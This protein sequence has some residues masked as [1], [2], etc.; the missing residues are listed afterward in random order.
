[1]EQVPVS[2]VIPHP[3]NARRGSIK[4]I[5]ESL[6][7]HGQY[8]PIIVSS[9]NNYILVGNN[10]WKAIKELGWDTISV[11]YIDVGSD[12]KEKQILLVDNRTSDKAGYDREALEKL[13]S[14]LRESL[15]GTGFSPTEAKSLLESS[16]KSVAQALEQAKI[17][18]TQKE[19]TPQQQPKTSFI[20]M[21]R[22]ATPELRSEI[23]AE[24]EEQGFDCKEL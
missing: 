2:A 23:R 12:E 7:A 11:E 9:R 3:D 16:A 8:K 1:M 21:V 18:R 6:L 22:F 4:D 13:V 20:L 5:K 14:S 19:L 10:T 15:P 17:E 24:L